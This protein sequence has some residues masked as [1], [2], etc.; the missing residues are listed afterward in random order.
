[1]RSLKSWAASIR[2]SEDLISTSS[3]L[4]AWGHRACMM[5]SFCTHTYYLSATYSAREAL[6]NGSKDND[7][8]VILITSGFTS[9]RQALQI[10]ENRVLTDVSKEGPDVLGQVGTDGGQEES[11]SLYEAP[12]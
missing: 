6:H 7:S 10:M 1:M 3:T 5:L 9:Q 11:L 8:L 4:P 2:Y 12:H